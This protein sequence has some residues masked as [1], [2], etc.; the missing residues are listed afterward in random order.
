MSLISIVKIPYQIDN[1]FVLNAIL[2]KEKNLQNILGRVVQKD[3]FRL[4]ISRLQNRKFWASF[5][6]KK[7]LQGRRV[8]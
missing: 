5:V 6:Y 2:S 7:I 4:G 8:V 1:E 3:D